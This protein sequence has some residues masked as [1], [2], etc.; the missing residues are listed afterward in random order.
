MSH[1][2]LASVLPIALALAA[3]LGIHWAAWAALGY[4]A[5]VVPLIDLSLPRVLDR[6]HVEVES[7]AL[8]IVLGVLHLVLLP[9]TILGLSNATGLDQPA[10]VALFA[11]VAMIFGQISCSNAHELIHKGRALPNVLGRVVYATLFFG[12][13]ASAHPAVHH[14]FVA[15]SD[16]PNSAAEGESL[17][18]FLPRAWIGSFRAGLRVEIARLR[19]KGAPAWGAGNPFWGYGLFSALALT[20]SAAIG[21]WGGIAAHLA[22][23]LLASAQLLTSDYVQH[24]GLRRARL[25]DGRYEAVGPEHSWNA[26]DAFSRLMMLNAPLH[27]EHHLH[28][29]RP[30]PQLGRPE[31]AEG[32]VLPYSL[33]IMAGIACIPPLWKRVMGREL[34]RLSLA[35]AVPPLEAQLRGG[36]TEPA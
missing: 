2:V 33:P 30:F 6:R 35:A 17:Y 11:A 8:P 16:D 4:M 12:H 20:A 28:P 14:R 9:V 25:A 34:E 26:P 27:S 15:T 5:L 3:G 1:F 18:R 36:M 19:R 32:P 22:L 23:G 10:Q 21:G 31:G 13:H 7:D 29:T 24:Y